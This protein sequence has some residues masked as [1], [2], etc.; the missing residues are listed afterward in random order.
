MGCVKRAHTCACIHITKDDKL[1]GRHIAQIGRGNHND[2]D[3]AFHLHQRWKELA[4]MHMSKYLW[5]FDDCYFMYICNV[6]LVFMLICLYLMTTEQCGVQDFIWLVTLPVRPG[7]LWILWNMNKLNWIELN[8][9]ILSIM[10]S[11]LMHKIITENS[12]RTII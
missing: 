8:F 10:V 3:T 7:L 11:C 2:G 6:Y 4:N 1:Q 5:H 12:N 9:Y